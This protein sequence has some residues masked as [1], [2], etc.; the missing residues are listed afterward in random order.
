MAEMADP[1]SINSEPTTLPCI[2]DEPNT[3][4]CLKLA[5]GRKDVERKL[6]DEREEKILAVVEMKA[7]MNVSISLQG[8]VPVGYER[9]PTSLTYEVVTGDSNNMKK[10]SE[11][12]FAEK[13]MENRGELEEILEAR[14]RRK[15]EEEQVRERI[16]SR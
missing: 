14:K 10:A 8:G 15:L 1:S 9:K 12:K 6:R 16:G 7:L 4:E 2:D 5:P 11:D 13:R 3:R